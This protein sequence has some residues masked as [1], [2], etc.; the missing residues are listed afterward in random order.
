MEM[1]CKLDFLCVKIKDMP[2]LMRQAPV[3]SR[4]VV[5]PLPFHKA[6]P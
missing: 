1:Q 2:I 3:Q 6:G 5:M 4:E